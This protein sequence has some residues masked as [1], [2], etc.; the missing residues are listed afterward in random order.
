MKPS[1][2][3]RQIDNGY[4]VSLN[5]GMEQREIHCKGI[6]QVVKAIKLLM[7]EPE[8]EKEPPKKGKK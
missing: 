8:E 2:N 4:L 3:V 5:S 7:N 6:A 1:V